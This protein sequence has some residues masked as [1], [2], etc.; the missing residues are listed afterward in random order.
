ML[1]AVAADD[2]RTAVTPTAVLA[3]CPDGVVV[4]QPESKANKLMTVVTRPATPI[5]T[6]LVGSVI[7]DFLL[8]GV[9]RP[10]GLERTLG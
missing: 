5:S 3:G 2:S 6:M 1:A 7:S 4:V 8:L 10:L 9:S